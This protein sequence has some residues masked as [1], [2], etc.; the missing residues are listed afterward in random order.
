ME[1]TLGLLPSPEG[2][3]LLPIKKLD[4]RGGGNERREERN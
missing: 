4:E 1:L 3:F 2:F